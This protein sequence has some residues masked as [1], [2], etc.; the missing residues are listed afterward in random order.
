[1]ILIGEWRRM[2]VFD[3]SGTLSL[4]EPE[5]GSKEANKPG[6]ERSHFPRMGGIWGGSEGV[7]RNHPFTPLLS[8]MGNDFHIVV[9][10]R[11]GE[12]GVLIR[13]GQ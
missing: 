11:D 9:A 13:V 10:R 12:H 8:P 2:G 5:F 6:L 1:M 4:D 3:F 7:T